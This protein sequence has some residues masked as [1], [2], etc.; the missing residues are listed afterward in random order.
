MDFHEREQMSALSANFKALAYENHRLVA[1]LAA[2]RE[3]LCYVSE[4]HHEG[5]GE[6]DDKIQA[7]LNDPC[8]AADALLEDKTRMDWLDS[9]NPYK[10]ADS[11]MGETWRDRIDKARKTS[12]KDGK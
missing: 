6:F 5:D 10:W 4:M 8:L 7:I 12:T 2:A 9:N 11:Y 1:Q 3:A